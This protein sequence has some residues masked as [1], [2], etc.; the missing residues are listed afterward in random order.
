MEVLKRV[1]RTFGPYPFSKCWSLDTSNEFSCWKFSCYEA[2]LLLTKPP[3]FPN[4]TSSNP[5][6]QRSQSSFFHQS[7]SSLGS[8]SSHQAFQSNYF[9]HTSTSS[10]ITYSHI[11]PLAVRHASFIMPIATDKKKRVLP[12]TSA[13][14][15]LHRNR[16]AALQQIRQDRADKAAGIK[17]PNKVRPQ[18]CFLLPLLI[19]TEEIAVRT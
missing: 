14:A 12:T 19:L 6:S 3:F 1:C 8:S 10:L 15:A 13:Q 18:S 17:R 9:L 2:P 7:S 5:R 16:H 11:T 4:H